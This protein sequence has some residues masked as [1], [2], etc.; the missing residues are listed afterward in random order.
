[1]FT[2]LWR[3]A[4]CMWYTETFCFVLLLFVCNATVPKL[5]CDTDTWK[6]QLFVIS[7]RVYV[8]CLR[9]RQWRCSMRTMSNRDSVQRGRCWTMTVFNADDVEPWQCSMRTMS[10]PDS[11]QCRWYRTM[12][13]FNAEDVE[14]WQCSVRT[15][16]NYHSVQ[17]GR[18]RT[19]IVFNADNIEPL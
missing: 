8:Y 3:I 10:I 18:Y 15:L 16:S 1:M 11:V 7:K 9:C 6:H 13:V 14:P 4:Y 5:A 2:T 17:Y 19:I 12:I